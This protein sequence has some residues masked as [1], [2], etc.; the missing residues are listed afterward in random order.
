MIK[1][2]NKHGMAEQRRLFMKLMNANFDTP[3][4][5]SRDYENLSE[6]EFQLQ[7]STDLGALLL[8]GLGDGVFLRATNCVNDDVI[9]ELD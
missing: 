5:I 2:N 1:T 6:E 8:D 7:A 3:V 4:I 9:I